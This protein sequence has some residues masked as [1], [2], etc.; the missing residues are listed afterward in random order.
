MMKRH[1]KKGL[2]LVL[3]LL[4]MFEAPTVLPSAFS[5]YGEERTATVT[6]TTLNVRSGPGT[7]NSIVGQITNGTAVTVL[8][9]T[10]GSDGLTWYQIRFTGSS[11]ASSVGYVSGTY[12]RFAASYSADAD[13]E[14]YLNSQG[15][16]ES[17]RPALRE[18]HAKYPQW[19]F[20]AMDTGL[21]WNEA[22]E[23]ES[24]VGRNLVSSTSI[25]SWKSTADG[26]Y[27]WNTSTWP[28][29]DGASWVAASGDII[30]YYMDPR[31][32]L[33]ETYIFQFLLQ[34]YDSAIHTREGLA[35]LVKGTFLENTV[36]VSDSYEGTVSGGNTVSGNTGTAGNTG[37][38]GN[39][40]T[41]GNTAA[42]GG[43]GNTGAADS[44][45]QAGPGGE[46][47]APS[48]DIS[49][50]GGST[51]A[52][53]SQNSGVSIGEAPGMNISSRD[54]AAGENFGISGSEHQ[55]QRVTATTIIRIG[56]GGADRETTNSGDTSGPSGSGSTPSLGTGSRTASYV[57]ILMQAAKTSGVSPY[58]LAAMILQEQGITGSGG[59][60]AGTNG[61][62][63]YYNFEAYVSNGM[64]A[65]ERGLWYAAQ[66]GDYMRPWN[67]IDKAIIGGAVQYGQNYV[68]AG[69]NTFYLKKFNVQGSNLYKHQF[70]TN[71]QGAASE[72]AK[73]AEAYTSAMRQTALQF[74]I[75]VYRNMPADACAL[76]AG[77]G[78]PNNKLSSIIVDG[79]T[80]S[81]SFN[82]DTVVYDVTVNTSVSSVNVQASAIDSG[83]QISGTGAVALTGTVTEAKLLVTAANG[84]VREYTIRITRSDSGPAYGSGSAGIPDGA[85]PGASGGTGSGGQ[86][87][88]PGSG[89]TGDTG[90]ASGP[91]GTAGTGSSGMLTGPG[92]SNVTI[93]G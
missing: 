43:S 29:F 51:G 26:A 49:S 87:A 57:D 38:S 22:V 9:Q 27:D 48:V 64:T 85:V 89:S 76:P 55:V 67:S 34:S 42:N 70:M 32:F 35:S 12:L 77:D 44:P 80:L 52:G 14:A 66:S 61:Y 20:T 39:T 62:Y 7:G 50:P 69:Q 78:S 65:V 68:L 33:N 46:T 90:G 73:M 59:C 60:I 19:V 82:R 23:N 18:L 37:P 63:N 84:A 83:A 81:P 93:V 5:V 40:G 1:W 6:A 4:M 45:V 54:S 53:S 72:G 13:F 8:G 16:P 86:T 56:P 92:G 2:A 79:F 15:F 21:D 71:V 75:P 47:A 58:V 88:G 3:S 74:S 36:Y 30:R 25:S 41:S 28:G 17:Y 31:N 10:T 24:L 11:G 91:G